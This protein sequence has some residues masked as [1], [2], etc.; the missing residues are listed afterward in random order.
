[1]QPA[2]ER[3]L[4]VLFEEGNQQPKSISAY[5]YDNTRDLE[6]SSEHVGRRCRTL[7][8][9]GLL[10]KFGAGVYSITDLGEDYLAGE[11]DAGD[12]EEED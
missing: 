3:I 7:E 10:R 11:I 6:Y 9:Y 12:L 8:R 4:E 1:M 5:I 2:D